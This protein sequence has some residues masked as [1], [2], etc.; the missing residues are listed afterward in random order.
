[1]T[2]GCRRVSTHYYQFQVS[3]YCDVEKKEMTETFEKTKKKLLSASFKI[4]AY[5]LRS[6]NKQPRMDTLIQFFPE[7]V[8]QAV[9]N[10]LLDDK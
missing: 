9:H 10:K 3:W 7:L 6:I 8:W 2:S 4:A 1:V 5:Y